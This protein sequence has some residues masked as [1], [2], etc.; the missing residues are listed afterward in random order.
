MARKKRVTEN[1][2][3][4]ESLRNRIYDELKESQEYGVDIETPDI[5]YDVKPKRITKDYLGN[6]RKA[7]D[8]YQTDRLKELYKQQNKRN[9]QETMSHDDWSYNVVENMRNLFNQYSPSIAGMLNNYLDRIINQYGYGDV[10]YAFQQMPDTFKE[11]L[12][13]YSVDYKQ[14]VRNYMTALLSYLPD[15]GTLERQELEDAIESDDFDYELS[16]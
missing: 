14:R 9:T 7:I 1:Q 15:I 11:Y 4:Y 12:Q 5:F 3:E 6:I 16:D 10:A 8:K 13:D 2:K